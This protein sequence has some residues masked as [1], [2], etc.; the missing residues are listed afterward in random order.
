[1]RTRGGVYD[2]AVVAVLVG[3]HIHAVVMVVVVALMSAYACDSHGV[4]YFT[5][6]F[7]SSSQDISNTRCVLKSEA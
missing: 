6:P 2:S 3:L 7:L 4:R 5:P 1:M